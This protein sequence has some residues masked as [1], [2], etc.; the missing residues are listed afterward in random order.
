MEDNIAGKTD[1]QIAAVLSFCI[2]LP[3]VIDQQGNIIPV[4]TVC[5][6]AV[7]IQFTNSINN[8]INSNIHTYPNPADAMVKISLPQ[9]MEGNFNIL[10][11][12]GQVIYSQ[13][14]SGNSAELN[15]ETIA[16]GNY[17][18]Q[19]NTDSGIYHKQLIIQH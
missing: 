6:S 11:Q 16:S 9:I 8:Y 10:N 4:Q 1:D 3:Q 17:I 2:S 15:T 12:L 13:K 7:A 5:D 14:L 19:I 18:I